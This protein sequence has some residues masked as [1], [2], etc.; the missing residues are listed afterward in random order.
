M[1]ERISV[2]CT[3]RNDHVM[4]A[5]Y[6]RYT[7]RG[8]SIIRDIPC[9][10]RV[11]SDPALTT[12]LS[13]WIGDSYAWTIRLPLP[14]KF[15]KLMPPLNKRTEALQEDSVSVSGWMLVEDE[16]SATLE[17]SFEQIHDSSLFYT[18]LFADDKVIK[19]KSV[20]ALKNAAKA[21]NRP[22]RHDGIW[23]QH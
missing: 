8:W 12:N 6:D 16:D 15:N 17:T 19:R 11:T 1:E 4:E 21:F 18:Y 13:R 5:I 7:R 23:D 2:A 3:T 20:V 10:E 22:W 14:A 9:L